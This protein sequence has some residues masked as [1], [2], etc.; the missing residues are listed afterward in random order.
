MDRTISPTPFSIFHFLFSI[1]LLL[2]APAM[3]QVDTLAYLLGK[4]D[5]AQ[6]PDFVP[7]PASMASVDGMHLR[8]ET[9]EA[10]QRMR[11]AAAKDGVRL[12]VISAT[13]GFARQKGIWEGKWSGSRK[14]NGRSLNTAIPDPAAR[15]LEILRYSSMPGTSRHHWGTDFDINSLSPAYYRSGEGKRIYDWMLKHASD[16]GF[17]QSYTPKGSDRPHG[18]EE[19]AWH[20]SYR[21]L[22]SRFLDLYRQQVRP[23]HI[24][25]F[26]GADALPFSEV[27]RYVE[28]VA[29]ACK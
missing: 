12:V 25:G 2:S 10:F 1:Q 14:V 29:P 8:R 9:M 15:A 16:Y 3:A 5:A 22:S 24:T 28:C 23:E 4:F 19:E 7:V 6:H 13:R 26:D 18:Y 27:L 21:P 17:C 11:E 20:W